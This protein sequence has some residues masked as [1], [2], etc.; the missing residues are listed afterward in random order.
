MKFFFVFN[1]FFVLLHSL[2]QRN[3]MILDL[4][5]PLFGMVVAVTP[6]PSFLWGKQYQ[7]GD[8]SNHVSKLRS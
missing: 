2:K 8:F 1:F 5:I 3:I 7:S 4:Y 6:P